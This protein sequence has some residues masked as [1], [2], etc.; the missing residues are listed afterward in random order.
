MPPVHTG[1]TVLA[2]LKRSKRKGGSKEVK[3]EL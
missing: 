1:V 3:K 2:G